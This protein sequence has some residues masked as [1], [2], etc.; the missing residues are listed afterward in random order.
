MLSTADIGI[1]VAGV[2]GP[3][4]GYVAAWRSDRRRFHHERALK[5]SDDLRQR[6]DDVAAALENLGAASADLRQV[7]LSYGGPT[8]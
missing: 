6:L 2:V 5:A 8:P 3:G 1:I 7:I 4:L